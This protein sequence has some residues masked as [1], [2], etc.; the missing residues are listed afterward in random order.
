MFPLRSIFLVYKY[1]LAQVDSTWRVL[2]G[3]YLLLVAKLSRPDRQFLQRAGAIYFTNS[4]VTCCPASPDHLRA[5]FPASSGAQLRAL[6]IVVRIVVGY[7]SWLPMGS[8]RA[9]Q[10]AHVAPTATKHMQGTKHKMPK[11]H[12]D[13]YQ[14]E[15]TRNLRSKD[16]RKNLWEWSATTNHKD[17]KKHKQ[18]RGTAAGNHGN[19]AGA[20]YFC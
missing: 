10:R 2:V 5:Q 16:P 8:Q 20:I 13:P 7:V 17:L 9:T 12:H 4:T 14:Q 3:C 1:N 11:M 18:A 15:R 6:D 19:S